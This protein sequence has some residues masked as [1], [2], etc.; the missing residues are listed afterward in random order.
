MINHLPDRLDLIATAEAGHVL[1][2]RIELA[3]LERVLPL[4]SS[5]AGELQIRLE[6]G[7]DQDGTCFVSGTITGELEMQCQRC[8]NP[9]VHPMNLKFLLGL[10]HAQEDMVRLPARFE[11]LL[12]TPEPV[13]IAELISDEILLAL[14][15]VAMHEEPDECR[16]LVTKYEATERKPADS[17]FAVLAQLKQKQ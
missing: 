13:R 11:P 15:I 9:F 17:P 14:P 16:E 5:S 10:V 3:R 7:K 2:G 1:Q 4:L 12:L 6:L 8:L